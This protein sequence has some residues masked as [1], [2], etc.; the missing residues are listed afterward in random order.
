MKV[1]VTG[2]SGMVGEGVLLE[3]LNAT[4]VTDVLVVGRRTCGVTH[5]KLKEV[6]H[7]DFM[8]LAPIEEQLKGYDACFFCLG[9]SSIGVSAEDYQRMTY[10]LTLEMGQRLAKLN[11]E[12]T[13]TYVTGMHTDSTEQGSVRW[14]RVK[15]ATENAL[16]KLFKN[17]YMFRPGAMTAVPGQKNL[18]T[19]Y[20]LFVPILFLVKPFLGKQILS[21]QEVG[22]AML[23]CARKHPAKHI[24]EISD[25]R[26]V[27]RA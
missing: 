21:L 1:I 5:P 20:H 4:D 3:T 24:L 19:I 14:A 10:D 25:I 26:D 7:K 18:K 8:N 27:S 17:A 22:Q 16:L 2:A 23:N 15:G 12:M 13:F 6:L 11:P 9:I